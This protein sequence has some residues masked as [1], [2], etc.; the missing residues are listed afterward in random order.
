MAVS[1][2]GQQPETRSDV[3]RRRWR[4]ILGWA[5]VGVGALFILLGWI[6]VSGEP[7]VARQLSYLASGGIGGLTAAV[8][9]IG[10]LI[11]EDL[12]SERRRLGRIEATLLDVNEALL[13]GTTSRAKATRKR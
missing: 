7:E 6:G 3:V 13:S 4:A 8:V 9:G 1:T 11:S 10:L 12:R 5:L 2:N